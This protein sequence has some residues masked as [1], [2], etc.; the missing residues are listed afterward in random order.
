M[1]ALFP[2]YSGSTTF[3]SD[4]PTCS[5]TSRA[6]SFTASSR[7][8]GAC[9]SSRARPG[10]CRR[11][12]LPRSA[13]DPGC[14]DRV[15][16]RVAGRRAGLLSAALPP[17]RLPRR[18]IRAPLLRGSIGAPRLLG[19][20]MPDQPDHRRLDPDEEERIA[21]ADRQHTGPA[22]SQGRIGAAAPAVTPARTRALSAACARRSS[23]G[24]SAR[25]RKSRKLV[26][27]SCR[28]RRASARA[29]TAGRLHLP[30]RAN[31]RAATNNGPTSRTGSSHRPA[32]EVGAD[33]H[34]A[35]GFVE[36]GGEQAA[37]E[38]PGDYRACSRPADQRQQRAFVGVVV[39]P[40]QFPST[41]DSKRFGVPSQ[42]A[43]AAAAEAA[44][45]W[46]D[47]IDKRGSG[48]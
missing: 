35:H 19:R 30:R 27:R 15:R 3:A 10:G 8:G 47:R 1:A 13:D 12:T 41:P 17:L 23:A 7:R 33:P 26:R 25:P 14:R 46:P 28:P 4:L 48:L 40:R 39:F 43:P 24:T 9:R 37:V 42:G 32:P 21:E 20:E 2:V 29:A 45:L 34:P 31:G 18:G 6:G 5:D 16:R 36:E 44:P 38:D 11:R 22:A